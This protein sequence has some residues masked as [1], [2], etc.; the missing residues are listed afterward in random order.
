MFSQNHS[1][2]PAVYVIHENREWTKPLFAELEALGV[3][4][5]DW[6]MSQSVID[7]AKPAPR[8][9]FYN[10]MS[11]SSHT[12]G[13]RFSPESTIGLLS[14]LESQDRVTLNGR[15]ALHLE[16]SKMVQYAALSRVGLRV[17]HTIAVSTRQDI[18]SAYDAL[19]FS[20]VIT[21]HN[22]AGKGLGVQLIKSQD[23]ARQHIESEAF[24]DS[25][26]GITLLQQYIE[27]A[28]NTITRAEFVGG[29]FLYAVKVNTSNGFELCP[30]D[31][32]AIGND[33]CPISETPRH[34]FEIDASFEHSKIGQMAIPKMKQ[35][36]ANEGLDVAAFEFV[37]N[38]QG[39]PFFYD[40]NTN[41]NYNSDAESRANMSAMKSLAGYLASTL[42][43][44]SAQNLGLAS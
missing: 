2:E 13:N 1:T 3:C 33:F 35:V 10:R 19:P 25:V 37:C 39:T 38:K 40:I 27:P 6:D 36:M 28:D 8:G 16:I 34:A 42:D 15:S 41:T 4:Y 20:D 12:R 26:D 5:H 22:R 7:L 24:T 32:C 23:A 21:K 17:P 9:V 29:E 14:W 30:A 43:S 11:A 31:V 18:L 44:S